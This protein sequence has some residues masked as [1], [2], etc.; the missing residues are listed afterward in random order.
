MS[1]Y[2]VTHLGELDSI[3]IAEGLVW[4]PVRRPLGIRAFGIN[5]YT[6]EE[7]GGHVVER[8]AEEL[9]HEEVY[10]VVSGR[11]RFVL[12]DDEIAAPRGD[13][14]LR[15][16][17]GGAARGDRRGAGNARARRR[18][19]ARAARRAVRRGRRRSSPSPPAGGAGTTPSRCTKRRSHEHP[20]NGACSTTSPARNA[21]AGG[22]RTRSCICN[23]PSKRE[24]R[25]APT[26]QTDTDFD[27][28]RGEPG[29]PRPR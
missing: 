24:Q 22:I 13:D 1:G 6:A 19:R 23:R 29:F 17:P 16:R 14:R 21:A 8:H 12:G 7:V 5:A 3:P 20:G 2:V 11:A 26:R 28:I 18:R 4:H 9:G 10:V 27:A 15:P 25:W